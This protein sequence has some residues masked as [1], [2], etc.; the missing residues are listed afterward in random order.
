M[1]IMREN[2]STKGIRLRTEQFGRSGLLARSYSFQSSASQRWWFR[3]ILSKLCIPEHLRPTAADISRVAA[4]LLGR[5]DTHL[6]GEVRSHEIYD[7]IH[8]GAGRY[9]NADAAALA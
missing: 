8:T 9:E 3:P 4:Y 6:A 1:I 2:F 7:A 5:Q